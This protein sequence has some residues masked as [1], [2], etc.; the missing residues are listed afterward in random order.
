MIRIVRIDGQT[1]KDIEPVVQVVIGVD[2]NGKPQVVKQQILPQD[3]IQL[4]SLFKDTLIHLAKQRVDNVLQRYG[5]NSLGDVIF[6]AN[7]ND[8]EAEQILTW[9]SNANG[10][11]YDDLIWD[12][13]AQNLD[14]IINGTAQKTVD[15][16]LQLCQDLVAVEEQIFQQS[17]QNNPLP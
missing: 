4:A 1:L 7:Q 12:W 13:I 2:K 11:G 14:P 8:T 9:Y 5:Y 10:N 16:V 6:Y 17:V 3:P 15:E